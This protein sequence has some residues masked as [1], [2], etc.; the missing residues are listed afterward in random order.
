MAI[1]QIYALR[2]IKVDAFNK[3][4]LLQNRAVL[5]RA[6]IDAIHDEGNTISI[7]P[8]DFQAFHLGEY[9]ES[10]GKITAKPAEHLFNLSDLGE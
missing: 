8:E 9:D 1:Q 3:P 6:L 10:T 7:H 2:D 5:E 4:V